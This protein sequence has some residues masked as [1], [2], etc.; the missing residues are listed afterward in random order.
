MRYSR[1]FT[2]EE[3]VVSDDHPDLASKI[4][5]TDIQNE[6]MRFASTALLQPTGDF[7]NYRM[8]I[9]S[10][11]RSEELNAAIGGHPLSHHKFEDDKG[12]VDFTFLRPRNDGA[13]L[14]PTG[15]RV[16]IFFLENL[17]FDKLIWYPNRNFFHL[18]FAHS[19]TLVY[20]RYS[21]QQ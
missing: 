7:F 8:G 14:T 4:T 18:Q 2:S 20:N 16:K 6:R 1:N 19:R 17:R 3:W 11:I 13:V 9:L 10:G 15:E 12:A 21:V 5:P